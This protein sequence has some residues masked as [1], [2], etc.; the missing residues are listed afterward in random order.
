MPRDLGKRVKVVEIVERDLASA[1]EL[2][3]MEIEA[4]PSLPNGKMIDKLT[5]WLPRFGNQPVL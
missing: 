1:E 3:E 4:Q 5:F 2:L